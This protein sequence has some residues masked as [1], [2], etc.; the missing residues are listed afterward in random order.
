M[1]L[2]PASVVLSWPTPNYDDPVTRG[3]ALIIVNSVFITLTFLILFAVCLTIVVLLANKSYGWDRHVWDIPISNFVPTYK[4]AMTAKVVFTAAASFTR[5]SLHCFY[6]RLV[7]DSGKSWFRWLVHFNVFYTISCFVSFTCIAIFFCVPISN[8]WTLGAPAETCLNEADA[9][10]IVGIIN[11]V[12][13]LLTTVTPIPLVMGL[14]MPLHQRLAVAFFFGMGFIVTAAGIVRT[15]FIYRSLYNEWDQ[16]WY[17]YPLWIAAAVEIDLGVMCASAPVLKPL[18]AKIPWSLS[19]ALTGGLSFKKSSLHTSKT[20]T[21]SQSAAF[22][23]KRRSTAPQS[24]PELMYDKGHSYEMKNW[25]DAGTRHSNTDLERGSQET[26]SE[27]EERPKNGTTRW[28]EKLRTKT[29]STRN[30]EDM[31]ITLTSQV[32]LKS[33]PAALRDGSASRYR[34][35]HENHMPLDENHMPLPPSRPGRAAS[36]N[37]QI[38]QSNSRI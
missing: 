9:T 18:L 22:M 29:T 31:T 6:Y 8:Y 13:D 35:F 10:L 7:S 23:S 32:E 19:G 37:D 16:T 36:T 17:A 14:Q 27:D 3:P 5:L 25:E 38:R 20:L 12:A 4:I 15:W 30:S 33:E 28:L 1:Q 24:V 2:P 21:T 26:G 11:C 34:S